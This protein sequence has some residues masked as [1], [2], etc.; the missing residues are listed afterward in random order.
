[1]LGPICLRVRAW[2]FCSVWRFFCLEGLLMLD[3]SCP[4]LLCNRYSLSLMMS[5]ISR[6]AIASCN[7]RRRPQRGRLWPVAC[8]TATPATV[9]GEN[10]EWPFFG[11]FGAFRAQVCGMWHE[12]AATPATPAARYVDSK[13]VWQPRRARMAAEVYTRLIAH[14]APTVTRSLLA[15]TREAD[16]ACDYRS[17]ST[18]GRPPALGSVPIPKPVAGFPPAPRVRAHWGSIPARPKHSWASN[19]TAALPAPQAPVGLG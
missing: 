4:G 19:Q 12:T 3:S 16:S 11:L 5:E 13:P 17:R 10:R 1:M 9:Q 6:R 14:A 18:P 7:E 2:S 8:G 15:V